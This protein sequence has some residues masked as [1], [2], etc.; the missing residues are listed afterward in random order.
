MSARNTNI[1]P[2][3]SYHRDDEYASVAVVVAL[4]SAVRTVHTIPN[5]S[6]HQVAEVVRRFGLRAHIG[7]R[8]VAVGDAYDGPRLAMFTGNFG[9]WL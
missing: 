1:I 9:D 2:E 7:G 8:H 3:I 5:A 4:D 6:R